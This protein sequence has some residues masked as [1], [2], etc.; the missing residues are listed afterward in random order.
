MGKV[1]LSP[2]CS[3]LLAKAVPCWMTPKTIWACF[4]FISRRPCALLHEPSVPWPWLDFTL[5]WMRKLLTSEQSPSF[6][7]SKVSGHFVITG[8]K[9][10]T[11]W[12][13]PGTFSHQWNSQFSAVYQLLFC[14]I[15]WLYRIKHLTLVFLEDF[16]SLFDQIFSTCYPHQTMFFLIDTF[17]SAAAKLTSKKKNCSR[18]FSCTKGVN[19][20][21]ST[22]QF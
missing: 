17:S 11:A 10:N 8:F 12:I 7:F 5:E 14:V 1:I 19:R 3:T 18:A 20:A 15:A 4:N 9:Q 13:Q 16:E 21:W 22:L 6:I 2:Y